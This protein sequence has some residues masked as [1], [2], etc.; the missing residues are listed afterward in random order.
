MMIINILSVFV[1]S[2]LLI[3]VLIWSIGFENVAGRGAARWHSHELD[4]EWA[5]IIII[6]YYYYYS[7][8][9]RHVKLVNAFDFDGHLI[10]IIR[11]VNRFGWRVWSHTTLCPTHVRVARM[12][13]L[14]PNPISSVWKMEKCHCS[15]FYLPVSYVIG[16]HDSVPRSLYCDKM[17]TNNVITVTIIQNSIVIIIEDKIKVTKAH[18][19]LWL[20]KQ[21][22]WLNVGSM[23]SE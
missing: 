3:R 13:K 4:Q 17:F 11:N 18:V 9:W 20:L 6:K 10:E 21:K 23:A 19:L 12:R 7:R 1:L 16:Y 2:K 15:A 5:C 22:R 14:I 8:R